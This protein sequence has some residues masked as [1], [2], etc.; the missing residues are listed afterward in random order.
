MTEASRLG[1]GGGEGDDGLSSRS[2]FSDFVCLATM[3]EDRDGAGLVACGND[4]LDGGP[5]AGWGLLLTA[6]LVP[7]ATMVVVATRADGM[8]G[9]DIVL[10]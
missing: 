3:V 8:S 2:R 5:A 9:A 1:N 6:L 4:A 10:V 7:E